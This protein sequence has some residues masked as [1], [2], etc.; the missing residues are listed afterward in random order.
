MLL[1]SIDEDPSWS[2][3]KP[4]KANL[5]SVQ[6]ELV[7]DNFQRDCISLNFA[8]LKARH[9]ETKDVCG[10]L[11]DFLKLESTLKKVEKEVKMFKDVQKARG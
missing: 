5:V 3:A 9:K 6:Q 7:L 8:D 2:W 10:K 1:T 4:L 11:Q